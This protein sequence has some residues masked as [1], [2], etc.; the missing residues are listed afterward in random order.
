MKTK[1]FAFLLMFASI[2][3][4][5]D[6]VFVTKGINDSAGGRVYNT[7]LDRDSIH[8]EGTYTT[9]TLASVYPEPFDIGEYK[10]VKF[11][12]N[13]FQIDCRRNVKRVTYIAFK[14]VNGKIIVD[15][16]YPNAPDEQISTDL[17]DT[18]IKPYLCR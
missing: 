8:L 9:V 11:M 5:E 13:T 7:Y 3:S 17:V 4:A 15:E 14:D 12:V 10:G 16:S 1:L 2:A 6:I 18:K